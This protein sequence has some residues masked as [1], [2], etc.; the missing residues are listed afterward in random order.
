MILDN[1]FE[2]PDGYESISC[3]HNCG[4]FVVWKIGAS[5]GVGEEI[6]Y[7][8][9][10]CPNRFIRKYRMKGEGNADK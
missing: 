8:Y 7:H 3:I 2:L 1:G 9:A 5:E 6:D 10:T 4:Y